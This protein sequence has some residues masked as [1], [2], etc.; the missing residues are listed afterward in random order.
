ML[1]TLLSN[2]RFRRFFFQAI[3]ALVVLVFGYVLISNIRTEL[4][5][6]GL[7]IFP[8]VSTKGSFPFIDFSSDFLGQRA[9][10]N[11][12]Q[13]SFGFDYTANDT[14]F[15]ALVTGLLNTIQVSMIGSV[16]A[17]MLGVIVGVSVGVGV[18]VGV[19]VAVPRGA[20]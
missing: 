14:F 4:E 2:E 8:F 15:R 11:I 20:K 7:E 6:I 18:N 9:G 5:G 10:F 3:F 17:T 13:R 19:L 1:L 12:D 16:L